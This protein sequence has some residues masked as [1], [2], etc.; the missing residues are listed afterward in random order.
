MPV[1]EQK[2]KSCVLAVFVFVKQNGRVHEICI[3]AYVE[4]T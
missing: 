1:N 4:T 3:K 2:K